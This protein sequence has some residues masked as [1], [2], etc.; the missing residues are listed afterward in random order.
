MGFALLMA[1]GRAVTCAHVVAESMGEDMTLRSPPQRRRVRLDFPFVAP[2]RV[3]TAAVVAWRP[4]NKDGSGDVAGLELDDEVPAGVRPHAIARPGRIHGHRMLA[5]GYQDPDSESVP[6][7]VPGRVIAEARP[8]WLQLGLHEETGGLRIRQGFSGSPVW[9]EQNGQVIGLVTQAYLREEMWLA[10]AT[11]A[12]VVLDAWPELRRSALASCPF[13]MLVPFEASDRELFFGRDEAVARTVAC[14]LNSEHTLVA[15]ASGAGKTSLVRAG[16]APELRERGHQVLSIRLTRETLWGSIAATL[17]ER[18]H[19]GAGAERL[20]SEALLTRELTAAG[21]QKAARKLADLL[22]G[23]RVVLI[24]DQFEDVLHTRVQHGDLVAELGRLPS[25]RWKGGPIIRVVIVMRDDRIGELLALAPYNASPPNQVLLGPMDRRQLRTVIEEPVRRSG[26]AHFEEGLADLIIDEIHVQPYS[27]PALQVVLTELWSR[28]GPDGTLR[29][30]DYQ[31]LGHGGGPLAA[32]LERVW[33]SLAEDT[34]AAAQDLFLHLVVPLENGGFARRVVTRG[35]IEAQTWAAVDA[36]AGH[37]LL[38]LRGTASGDATAE[39][40]HDALIEQWPTLAR[41]LADNRELLVWRED[42]RRTM[43]TWRRDGKRPGLLLHGP[44]LRHGLARMRDYSTHMSPPE[45]EFLRAGRARRTKRR[46]WFGTALATVASVIA[47]TV[48]YGL[49]QGDAASQTQRDDLSRRL[50]QQS[51]TQLQSDPTL[52]ALLAAAAWKTSETPEARYSMLAVQHTPNRA[53]LTGTAGSSLAGAFSPDGKILAT[54][55]GNNDESVRLWDMHA[56][57]FLRQLHTGQD[58]VFGVAFSPDGRRVAAGSKVHSVVLIN[59][60]GTGRKVLNTPP[61]TIENVAFSP[62]GR[63]VAGAGGGVYLWDTAT[64]EQVIPPIDTPDGSDQVAFT[65]DG[66]QLITGGQDGHVRFWTL[67]GRPAGTIK[68]ADTPA[69]PPPTSDTVIRPP[70]QAVLGM[71]LSPDG[72]ML[73]TSDGKHRVRLWDVATRRALPGSFR[74]GLPAFSLDGSIIGF[75]DADDAKV[76]KLWDVAARQ[77]I[78]AALTGHVGS[79]T[80]IAFGRDG[81]T[82]ATT[83]ADTTV[84]LWDISAYR[85]SMP[86]LRV[87]D[88]IPASAAPGA[89]D[90]SSEAGTG[91]VRFSPDGRTLA[92]GHRHVHLWNLASRTQRGQPLGVSEGSDGESELGDMAFSPDSRYL[93]TINA[94]PGEPSLL[95]DLRADPPVARPI[96]MDGEDPNDSVLTAV[97]FQPGGRMVT[98]GNRGPVRIWDTASLKQLAVISDDVTNINDIALSPDG[99]LMASADDGNLTLRLWDLQKRKLVARINTGHAD[100]I[101]TVAFSSRGS[102][103]ATGAYDPTPRLFDARTHLPLG[104]PLEGHTQ[105]VSQLVFSP[106]GRTLVTASMDETMRLWDVDTRQP[107]GPPISA[108]RGGISDLAFRPDGRILATG[109]PDGL[110]RFWDQTPTGDLAAQMCRIAGRPLTESEWRRYTTSQ[111]MPSVCR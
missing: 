55:G 33:R 46:V 15:G 25:A 18:R 13:R 80:D 97:A 83:S 23:D 53:T 66:R 26:F 4:M 81:R 49:S 28:Q 20:H 65:G 79:V 58:S 52:A 42:L 45:R 30:T 6:T 107:I 76:V 78:G 96:I 89:P 106:D 62:D 98:T 17:A 72:R 110:V 74:G 59:V 9:D 27:L 12:E 84:R 14:V 68:V 24:V 36:L 37:R 47:V 39:L 70:D 73:V 94:R 63:L 11:T 7:W 101:Y 48:L 102:V 22:G 29:H 32:H 100:S 91:E 56:H 67:T 8:G 40:V 60:D 19:P 5:Y 77:P 34:R 21:T 43:T 57:R 105:G 50:A 111:E 82:V 87:A 88:P 90:E 108:H 3:L 16:V 103:V 104:T 31:E 10:Y 93:A 2:G 92:T 95:W 38:V 44:A 1:P 71:D 69:T 99:R 54:G 75:T 51:R 61:G 41:Y 86:A 64:G 109:G 35:E 85:P